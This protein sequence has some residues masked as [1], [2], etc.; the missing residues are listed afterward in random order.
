MIGD[1][2]LV[3]FYRFDIFSVKFYRCHSGSI[4]QKVWKCVAVKSCRSDKFSQKNSRFATYFHVKYCRR[5]SISRD[6]PSQA[7]FFHNR[8]HFTRGVAKKLSQKHFSTVFHGQI[9]NFTDI[10]HE[11]LSRNNIYRGILSLRQYSMENSVAA[12]IFHSDTITY[13]TGRI[14][15]LKLKIFQDYSTKTN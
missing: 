1:N 13:H 3:K 2:I 9:H 10:F 12:C 5:Y 4:S 14:Q 15:T 7:T 11:I 6:I 8:L